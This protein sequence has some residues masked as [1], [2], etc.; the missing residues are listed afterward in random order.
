MECLGIRGSGE[1]Y[2]AALDPPG[3]YYYYPGFS[4]LVSVLL[5][6]LKTF[7]YLCLLDYALSLPGTGR[8]PLVSVEDHS[9]ISTRS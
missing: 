7:V 3:C 4:D 9:T 6:V 5:P 8:R 1:A 2:S